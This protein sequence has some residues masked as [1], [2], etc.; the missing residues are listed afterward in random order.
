VRGSVCV[1]LCVVCVYFVCYGSHFC[2]L[3]S[4]SAWVY[5][6]CFHFSFVCV[7]CGCVVICMYGQVYIGYVCMCICM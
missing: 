7:L 4:M 1:F 5:N 3:W 2:I 6:V